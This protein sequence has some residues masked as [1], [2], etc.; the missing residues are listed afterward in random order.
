MTLAER[1]ESREYGSDGSIQTT[2]VY[3]TDSD[4]YA[5]YA[6]LFVDGGLPNSLDDLDVHFRG[7]YPTMRPVHAD[8]VTDVGIWEVG[9]RYSPFQSVS[10]GVNEVRVRVASSSTSRHIT[11]AIEH[12]TDYAPAAKTP[13]NHKGAFG[14][15]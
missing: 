10:L 6:A 5:A 15:T 8:T 11:Q 9:C 1:P 12:V 7:P 13:T 14:V 4:A 3:Q 2:W